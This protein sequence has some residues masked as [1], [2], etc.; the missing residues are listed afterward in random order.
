VLECDRELRSQVANR[1]GARFQL[2]LPDR[3]PSDSACSTPGGVGLVL[4]APGQEEGTGPSIAEQARDWQIAVE[5]AETA[6]KV[7]GKLPGGAV[8]VLEA[9]QA[10]KVDWRELLRRAWFETIPADYSWMRPNLR[11]VW[12]GI[13]LPEIASG[14]ESERSQLRSTVWG[15]PAPVSW[16]FL[17]RRFGRSWQDNGRNS[18]R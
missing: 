15:R 8:R 9:S 10:T 1:S 17:K 3:T 6:A 14:G 4:D 18:S 16:D 11:H 12:S 7:A 5:Q 13:Y 2:K